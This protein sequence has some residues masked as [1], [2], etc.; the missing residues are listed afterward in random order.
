[1]ILFGL[2]IGLAWPSEDASSDAGRASPA[3]APDDSDPF[4]RDAPPETSL[5]RESDGHFYVNAE[6]NG[7]TVRFVVDTG[8]SSV[9]LTEEDARRIGLPF[10]PAEFRVIGQGASGDVRG[11]TVMLS[12]VSVDGKKV[13]DVR[14]A[15]IQGGS[16]SLLGQSYLAALTSVNMSR[17]TMTL[18]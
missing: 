3:A 8:A 18:R 14:G 5:R 11:T 7:R 16:L 6:V 13:H 12:T 15:I 9:A 1:M 17:D 4:S 2:V 10:N